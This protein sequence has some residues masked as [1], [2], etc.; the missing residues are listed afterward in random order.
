MLPN[1]LLRAFLVV[2]C[3]LVACCGG[4][5]ETECPSGRDPDS[6]LPI[7]KKC[8]EPDAGD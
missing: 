2:T 5:V 3:A 1:M 8:D 4:D 7:G 6:G